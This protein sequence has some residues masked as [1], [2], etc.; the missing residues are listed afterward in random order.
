MCAAAE[1]SRGVATRLIASWRLLVGLPLL[2]AFCS[3][4][5][6][7]DRAEW[8]EEV[9][10]SNGELIVVQRSATRDKSG[11][12]ASKRGSP[13]SWEIQFPNSNAI[14]RS[15]GNSQPVAVE[16]R[17]GSAYLVE[18]IQ[19]RELCAKFHNPPASLVY[20]RHD[21]KEWVQIEAGEYPRG[22]RANLLLDPWGRTASEDARGLLKNED[23]AHR[24]YNWAVH[25]SLADPK[26]RRTLDA[27]QMLAQH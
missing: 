3:S 2:M 18:T 1:I 14:W 22:G 26:L 21:G 5:G 4:C 16:V 27:C 23:K 13:R 9:Q 8:E 12:P 19:S 17:P 10:L 15:D 11:F 25:L 7:I 6:K 24:G 20:Y